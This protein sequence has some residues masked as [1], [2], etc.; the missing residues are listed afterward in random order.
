MRPYADVLPDYTALR[1]TINCDV[2][3]RERADKLHH[4]IVENL[5]LKL[6]KVVFS[7]YDRNPLFELV[8]SQ[9]LKRA[10]I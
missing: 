10:G 8:A 9:I 5:E 7:K 1:Y 6:A 3:L 4:A 2:F